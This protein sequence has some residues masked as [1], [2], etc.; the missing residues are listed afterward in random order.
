MASKSLYLKYRP[1]E[2]KD[3]IGQEHIAQ[4]L[5][6]A[7]KNN[8]IAHAYLFCGPRGTGKT[9]TA[10]LVAKALNC[11]KSTTEPCN[12]C[13]LCKD[14]MDGKLIDIIE[15]DAASNRGIDEIRDLK[16]KINFSPTRGKKKIYIIDEVHML[17]KEA[18]NAL[19]KTLEEPPEHSHFILATT[20]IHKVPETIIS[21]C[22]KFNFR[23]IDH[24]HITM[25]LEYISNAESF[26]TEKEALETIAQ[27]ARGGMRDAIGLLEQLSDGNSIITAAY[28][29]E[30]LGINEQSAA[31]EF[32]KKIAQN[33]TVDALNI[34]EHLYNQG[35]DLFEF[36]KS[37][38]HYL[39]ESLFETIKSGNNTNKIIEN[40]EILQDA[41]QKLKSSIIPQLPLEIAVVKMC[42]SNQ[43]ISTTQ[44]TPATPKATE[45]SK[46]QNTV[47]EPTQK[48][49]PVEQ[50]PP[51]VSEKKIPDVQTSEPKAVQPVIESANQ[52]VSAGNTPSLQQ[53]KRDWNKI[54]GHI[55]SPSLK[56]SLKEAYPAELNQSQLEVHINSSFHLEKINN[57]ENIQKLE[58]ALETFTQSVLKVQVILTEKSLKPSP[59][60]KKEV[61]PMPEKTEPTPPTHDGDL[62]SQV[63][64]I[65]GASFE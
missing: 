65:F 37:A 62:A 56:L 24:N 34:I 33:E 36:C 59:E 14:A 44:H 42:E 11:E 39:R 4:T 21:R 53:L 57:T 27:V 45:N 50:L 12:E 60:L 15:I 2:F 46:Q 29:N 58:A 10:R 32:C 22:Q 52:E 38:T 43:I 23:R 9:S 35:V 8:H 49:Q 1:Q 25:R 16:E 3:L 7:L 40:I 20:E 47:T 6:N 55:T 54:I 26:N 31:E 5:Q 18:F 19:L 51:Q 64:D 30:S 61:T 28:V 41:G 48:T 63:A 17:T 13:E